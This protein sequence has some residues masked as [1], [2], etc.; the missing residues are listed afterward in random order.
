[1]EERLD[2]AADTP[3][4][5]CRTVAELQGQPLITVCWAMEGLDTDEGYRCVCGAM[6]GEH[7]VAHPHRI[8]WRPCQAFTLHRQGE[9]ALGISGE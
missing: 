1:M 5:I 7:G 9:L 6:A 2:A 8:F 4:L 3:C